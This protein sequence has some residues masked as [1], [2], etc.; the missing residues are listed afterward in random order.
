MEIFGN[1]SRRHI[2]CIF[3]QEIIGFSRALKKHPPVEEKHER[4][5]DFVIP[6]QAGIQSFFELLDF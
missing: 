1:R 3:Q 6:A 5:N 2:I 4:T